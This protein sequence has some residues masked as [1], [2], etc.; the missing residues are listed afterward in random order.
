MFTIQVKVID[1][2]DQILIFVS[3][4]ILIHIEKREKTN[5]KV[6]RKL[7]IINPSVLTPAILTHCGHLLIL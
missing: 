1:G 4:I 3:Y 7:L 6:T 5:I 2:F